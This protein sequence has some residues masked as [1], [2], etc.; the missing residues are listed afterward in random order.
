MPNGC[1]NVLSCLKDTFV[2]LQPRNKRNRRFPLDFVLK[3]IIVRRDIV[4]TKPLDYKRNITS[5]GERIMEAGPGV[6]QSL[7]LLLLALIWKFTITIFTFGIKVPTGLFIPSL[8]MGAIMGRVVGVGMQ[9]L[10]LTYRDMWPFRAACT[11][12]EN[13][14]APGLYAMIGAAACLAG[15]TRMTVS[16]VVIMFELTGRVD[17]IV[18][19]MATVV[20]SKWVADAIE[21]EGIYDAHIQLNHYPFLDNKHSF[22][23]STKAI[24]LVRSAEPYREL[25]RLSQRGM[26]L[27][28]IEKT[29]KRTSHNGFPI[30]IS[31]DIPYL[32]GFVLRRDLCLAIVQQ[33]NKVL[34]IE[35]IYH[36]TKNGGGLKAPDEADR[37]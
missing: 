12:N 36:P 27:Q 17:Y 33:A 16:L 34:W 18:P 8:A 2:M 25:H 6:N 9:Q 11:T 26:T 28:D 19:L 21:R 31:K 32:I 35:P 5:V 15:V 23:Y 24:D 1:F 14:M 4:V 29:L 3:D 22:R 37:S 20:A 13:C 7:Y 10:A 30:T